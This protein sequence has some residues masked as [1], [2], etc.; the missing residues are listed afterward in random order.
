[1]FFQQLLPLCCWT[2]PF[3][4]RLQCLSLSLYTIIVIFIII[5]IGIIRRSKIKI[6]ISKRFPFISSG[7]HFRLH[8]KLQIGGVQLVLRIHLCIQAVQGHHHFR[9]GGR[10]WLVDEVLSSDDV[11][12][13]YWRLW[14][15]DHRC[16]VV[17]MQ[18]CRWCSCYGRRRRR[19]LFLKPWTDC[20]FVWRLRAHLLHSD[21][22]LLEHLLGQG[23]PYLCAA[24]EEGGKRINWGPPAAD[25]KRSE[26]SPLT[27]FGFS[28]ARISCWDLRQ[29]LWSPSAACPCPPRPISWNTDTTIRE[30][31]GRFLVNLFL[32]NFC[33]FGFAAASSSRPDDWTPP[34][35]PWRSRSPT[36]RTDWAGIMRGGGKS[37]PL[38]QPNS[39]SHANFVYIYTLSVWT[40][41]WVQ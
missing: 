39:F 8:V 5:I 9:R 30:T 22:G 31:S 2:S 18:H 13:S 20:D 10:R 37:E 3:L 25:K 26:E 28:L 1:M 19:L 27:Q 16:A 41:P 17:D 4:Y 21:S 7:R 34:R 14:L 11:W 33:R 32:T 24:M 23:L 29:S 35:L 15:N 12:C 38:V 6:L 36:S 40:R